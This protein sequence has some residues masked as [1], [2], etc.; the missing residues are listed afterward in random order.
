MTKTDGKVC[1]QNEHLFLTVNKMKK[2]SE[3]D[4]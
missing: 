3:W 4:T 2:E 1:N